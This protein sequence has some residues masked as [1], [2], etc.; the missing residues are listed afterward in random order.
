[1]WKKSLNELGFGNLWIS[2]NVVKE[3]YTLLK[4]KQ[5]IFDQAK[6]NLLYEIQTSAKCTL[7]KHII[8]NITLQFYLCKHIPAHYKKYITKL[9]LSSLDLEIERGRYNKIERSNRIC[10]LCKNDVED[11][12]HFMLICPVFQDLRTKFIKLY[13]R[14]NPSFFKY[15]QLMCT[16]N[17]KDLINI[18]KYIYLAYRL[19]R[20]LLL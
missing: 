19:R 20:S 9:R 10:Q 5:R 13:Y 8:M 14:Q 12:Y 17:S 7:Y 1:M 6:Q 11:E 2:Q 16:H 3:K 18:G 4:I 15:I